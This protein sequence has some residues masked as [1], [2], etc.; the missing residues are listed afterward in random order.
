M[1]EVSGP[2]LGVLTELRR[3]VCDGCAAGNIPIPNGILQECVL[4]EGIAATKS[5]DGRQPSC[6][7][8]LAVEFNLGVHL[9]LPRTGVLRPPPPAQ[10]LA[11]H[12]QPHYV[13]GLIC[14]TATI[15]QEALPT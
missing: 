6:L 15:S 11:W 12:H 3:D 10:L 9:G 13:Q 4:Y 1:S 8:D 2:Q 14:R 5:I 7:N